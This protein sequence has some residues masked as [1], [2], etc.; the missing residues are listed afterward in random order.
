MRYKEKNEAHERHSYIYTSYVIEEG[1]I[2]GRNHYTS[3]DG[4]SAIAYICNKWNIQSDQSRYNFHMR[5][6]LVG[7]KSLMKVLLEIY[8]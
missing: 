8:Y 5:E 2:N 6:M 1:K 3:E 4:K 7:L